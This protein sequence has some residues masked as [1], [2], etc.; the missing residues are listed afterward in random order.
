M[1]KSWV[2]GFAGMVGGPQNNITLGPGWALGGP[3][4]V[5]CQWPVN[6]A[7]RYHNIDC[8]LPSLKLKF[9]V[10]VCCWPAKHGDVGSNPVRTRKYSPTV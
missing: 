3:G 8:S 10:R 9:G 2:E 6:R 5:C 4:S 1:N 7:E